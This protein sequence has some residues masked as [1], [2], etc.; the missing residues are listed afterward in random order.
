MVG[1]FKKGEGGEPSP[2]SKNVPSKKASQNPCEVC[3]LYKDCLTPKMDYT[4]DGRKKILIVAEAPGEKEDHRGI[5]LIG[6]AGQLL[7]T[8]LNEFGL[9]L[10]KDFWKTNS[11][12]CRPPKNRK[13]TRKELKCCW[14]RV[15]KTIEALQ[16]EFI[17]LMGGTAVTAFYMD[18]FSDLSINIWRKR[19]IPDHRFGCY[20]I[21]MFHPSFILR[22][23]W[24]KG[25]QSTFLD[26]IEWA[27]SCRVKEFPRNYNEELNSKAKFLQTE[28]EVKRFLRKIILEE[29]L[30]F[31]DYETSSKNPYLDDPKIWTVGINGCSFGLD[32]PKTKYKPEKVEKLL[33]NILTSANVLKVAHNVKFEDAWSRTRFGVTPQKWVHDTMVTQHILEHRPTSKALKFQSFVKWGVED[34]ESEMK[35]YLSTDDAETNTLWKMPIEKLCL[36]NAKDT[37]LTEKLYHCQQKELSRYDDLKKANDLFHEGTLAFCDVE[38]NGICVDSEWYQERTCE[39]TKEIEKIKDK[40]V[41]GREG[42]LFQKRTGRELKLNSNKDLTE[43]FFTILKHKAVKMTAKGS[44]SVD[45]EALNGLNSLFAKE[46]LRYRKLIK[47]RDTY[48]SQFIR[49]D[50]HG[51]IHPQFL[52]HSVDSFRSCIAKGTKVYVVKDFIAGPQG[53]PIENVQKGDL[54][55]CFNDNLKPTIKKVVWAGKTGTREVIRIYWDS[56]RGRTGF[57]DLTPEHKVRLATGKYRRADKLKNNDKVLTL[58]GNHKIVKVEYTQKIV[59]V[60]DVEVES[61][62]NFIANEICVH[63]SCVRPNFQNIPVRDEEAKKETRSGVIPS[64]GN[65]LMEIDYS[66]MEVRIC[67]CYTHDPVLIDYVNNPSTDMHRDQAM[68]LFKLPKEEISEPIRFYAK[69]GFVFPEIYGSYYKNVAANLWEASES[70]KIVSDIPLRTVMLS[71]GIG[72]LEKFTNHVQYVENKFWNKFA[73]IKEW[74]ERTERNYLKKGYITFLFGHRRSGYLTRNMICN[75]PIQGAAFHCLLWSFIQLNKIRKDQNWKTKI[76]GQ[77]HDSIIFDLF[78]PEEKMV[79]KTAQYIMTEKIREVFPFLI[80][81]LEAKPEITD[82]NGSWYTKRKIK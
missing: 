39:I 29:E 22:N 50:I 45:V 55:Y 19:L 77:I 32:H 4:G 71:S 30:V 73:L 44:A 11:C 59:D 48:L 26:D 3:G 63:N 38:P 6:E 78:P 40:L 8:A 72:D 15:E 33:K 47:I 21:P 61:V 68:E 27:L 70:L 2:S 69:N 66:A 76:L 37:I 57:L 18:R 5:Q 13:P 64:P 9:D 82:V 46:L 35:S 42:R 58:Y 16:P 1:F 56:D 34:Y 52:L 80:V 24:D 36:Y 17:W 81:S 31:I 60:Y 75:Y 7:R 23:E 12:M 62:H 25:L 43:L 49:E 20:V 53:F 74:Q 54:V 10:D 51:K 65:K 67:A 14:N 41:N 28:E 79:I